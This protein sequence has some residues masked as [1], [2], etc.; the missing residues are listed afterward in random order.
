MRL[1]YLGVLS[2]R[3]LL[4]I[5]CACGGATTPPSTRRELK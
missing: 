5:S 4:A 2:S 3:T 1:T